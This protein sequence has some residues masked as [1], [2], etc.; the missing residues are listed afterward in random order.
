[1]DATVLIVD[2]EPHVCLLMAKIL[3]QAGYVC[4][5]AGNVQAAKQMLMQISFD[6]LL[7]DINMPGESG[8]ELARHVKEHYPCTAV[9]MVTAV[10]DPKQ[11]KEVL[12][13]GVYG[14][15]VK[16]FTK[17]LVLITVENALRRHRLE[18]QE[19]ANIQLL[20]E[21]V[22]ER[23]RSLAEQLHLHQNLIDAIPVPVYYK[24]LDGKYLGCNL[25]FATAVNVPRE[26]IIGKTVLDVHAAIAGESLWSK[27]EEL[28][29]TGG[30]Q[31]YEQVFPLADG[32]TSTGIIHKAAF[33]DIDGKISGLIGVRL[34]I[35]E[36]KQTEQALRASEGKLRSIMDNLQIGVV[37]ID[38]RMEILGINRQVGQ[39]FPQARE[40]TGKLC[41]QVFVEGDQQAPCELCPSQAV[42]ATGKASEVTLRRETAEGEKFFRALASPMYDENGEIVAALELLEDVTEALAAEREL[43]QA[44]KLEAVGQLAAGIAHEI[45]TPVQ[46]IGDN[47]RFLEDACRDLLDIQRQYAALV[48]KVK[49]L[50][51]EQELVGEIEEAVEAA[52]MPFLA[53]EVPKTVQQS[54][55]GVNRVGKIVQAMREFSHPGTSEKSYV[56]INRAL[57]STLT[58]SRNEWKYVAEVATDLAPDLP[59]V[60][61]LPG[62]M[63]QVFLNIIVNAAH[64]IGDVTDGGNKGMGLIRLAT[65]AQGDKVEIRISDSGSGVPEAVRH[66]IFDPFFTTKKVGKGTG[67]GLAIARSVVV[68]KHQGAIRFETE[69]GRGTT[70]IIQLPIGEKP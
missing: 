24:G 40:A 52:D 3:E 45:N 21:K 14:Y 62:E 55:D 59:P 32:T 4:E 15:L 58:I 10:D 64:A 70:F 50:G 27:D 26:S 69:T 30:V 61:C 60:L 44:Q 20:E 2:D 9:V 35:T 47:I 28:F 66:R 57:E 49:E 12:D 5:R 22:A 63:N 53:E 18:Q 33:R 65:R 19:L 31:V 42:F 17:N 13:M 68:D 39:W 1:M 8:V 36:L 56:N 7:T 38:P 67:Q 46:Y 16:P 11:A 54:L 51:V 25:A 43:R 41:Y 34:D 23:T 48:Q 6:L 29:R 37:M